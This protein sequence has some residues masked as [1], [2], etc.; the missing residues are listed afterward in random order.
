MMFLRAILFQ[1]AEVT[2]MYL[3]LNTRTV[4]QRK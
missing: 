4:Q 2:D 3:K 1:K